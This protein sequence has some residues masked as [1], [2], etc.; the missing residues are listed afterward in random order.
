[1]YKLNTEIPE[2][3]FDAEER[4]GYYVSS[5]KKG[6]WAV[7]LDMLNQVARICEWHDI[8]WFADGGTLLGAARHSGFMPWD[9]DID[10]RMLRPD[11][12]RFCEVA[13]KELKHPYFF[14]SEETDPGSVRC[15]AQIR[16]SV[17]AGILMWEANSNYQNN[18]FYHRHYT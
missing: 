1:M 14:Q 16:N 6:V 13:K 15:H 18:L 12:D 7:L 3:F 17:T 9:D 5:E 4:C 10:I 2:S 11:Y 8:K